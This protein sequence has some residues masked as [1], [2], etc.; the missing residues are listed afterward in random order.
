VTECA[1]IDASHGITQLC[2]IHQGNRFDFRNV[3]A[4]THNR[5]GQILIANAIMSGYGEGHEYHGNHLLAISNGFILATG[6]AKQK[7]H[8]VSLKTH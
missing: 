2:I 3:I 5:V 7:A 1:P 4:H 8:Q 6:L